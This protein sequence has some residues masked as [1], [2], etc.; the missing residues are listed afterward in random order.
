MVGERIGEKE[1][2]RREKRKDKRG[3]ERKKKRCL[4]WLGGKE[5]T[6]QCRGH[7]FKP[8]SEKIP[9]TA[10]HHMGTKFLLELSP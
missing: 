7:R 2:K 10:E 9:Y 3:K 4:R 6:R 8:W 5:S 1:K